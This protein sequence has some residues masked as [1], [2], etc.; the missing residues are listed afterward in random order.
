MSVLSARQGVKLQAAVVAAVGCSWYVV[1]LQLHA[2]IVTQAQTTAA[3]QVPGQPL[4]L[5]KRLHLAT[6]NITFAALLDVA[7]SNACR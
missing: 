5:Y 7:V 2:D 6:V 4:Q 1:C 3:I